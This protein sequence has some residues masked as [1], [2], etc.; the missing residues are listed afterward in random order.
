ME[1]ERKWSSNYIN[2]IHDL[3]NKN[4]S[5]MDSKSGQLHIIADLL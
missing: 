3:S 2:V 4:V 1:K 5:I